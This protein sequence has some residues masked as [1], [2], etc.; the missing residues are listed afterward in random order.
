MIWR[1]VL[2]AIAAGAIYAQPP[3]IFYSDLESGPAGAIV[4]I[5]GKRFASSGTITAGGAAPA[6]IFSWSD[7]KISFQLGAGAATG[8]ITVQ[9]GAGTSNAVPFAIRPGR[10]YFVSPGGSDNNPG[11][12]SAPWRTILHARDEVSAGD[13]VYLMDGVA[14]TGDDDGGFNACFTIDSI[15]G[16]PG[17]PIAFVAYPG[18]T[19]TIGNVNSSGCDS[20][21]RSAGNGE[22]HWVFAGLVLRGGTEAMAIAQ[23]SDWR[24]VAN[25]LSCPNGNDESGCLATE[26]SSNWKFLGN[27]VHDTGAADATAEYQG[28]YFSTDS[29]HIEIGWNTIYNVHGCRGIQI[30]SS[31]L[32][33]GGA[34]DPT[35]F[36]QYDIQIHDNLIHDTQCDGIILATVD[37]SRGAVQ[38]YNNVI[39]NAGKGPNNPE[40]SGSWSCI[41]VPGYTNNGPEG[42]G[43]VQVFNN[44]MYNCGSFAN[45]PYAD[46]SAA[47][48]N[49]GGNGNLTVRMTNNI[50]DQPSSTPAPYVVVYDP[51]SGDACGSG[52]NCNGVQGS[53]NLFFGGGG[54]PA[55]A[56]LTQSLN[57]NPQFVNASQ[58]DFHLMAGSPAASGG[59][60]EPQ[61]TDFDGISLPQGAS[62]PIGAYAIYSGAAA[63][64]ISLSSIASAAGGPARAIAPGEIVTIAG[65]GL[66]P[67]SP[68]AFSLDPATGGIASTL[69]GTQIFFGA[70]AAPVLW[71]SAAQVQAMAPFEI[72]GQS[73]VAVTAS[74]Q[75][76]QS[77]PMTVSVAAAAPGIFTI[78]GSGSGPAAALNQD[79]SANSAANPA[80]AGSVITIFFT[81]GG[82]TNPPGATGA[83]SAAPA[84]LLGSMTAAVGGK[85][86]AILYSGAAPGLVSG[87]QQMNLQLASDTP[88]G[89]QPITISAASIASPAGP[90]IAVR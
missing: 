32:G 47:V 49:G 55:N 64:R 10:I 14:Q 23:G 87:V 18:A 52:Q 59:I 44:T 79:G 61:T 48:I 17:A 22:S 78:D 26:Q 75:S 33:D 77:A 76:A 68:A 8:A 58:F 83:V 50:A 36:N 56:N 86:A 21:I 42:G 74:F 20:G 70:I 2:C 60:T 6:S 66:G 82:Q 62:Y 69:D 80:A 38:V 12:F 84:P 28:V 9:N 85:T 54:P 72:A 63:P 65:G 7:R 90:T 24:V 41:C 88:S 53:N 29:N 40:K 19:A 16:A 43:S 5:Y 46:A 27:T 1:A 45:P 11:D 13:I 3:A 15:S 81:G 71:T 30:H 73:Q 25:D 4:T 39:Y 89:A 67:A 35:G 34:D 31:P 57:A 51:I 37:P